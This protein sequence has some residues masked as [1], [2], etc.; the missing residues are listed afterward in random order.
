V[1]AP[2]QEMPKEEEKK[3]VELPQA[4]EPFKITDWD[5]I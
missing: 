4:S 2:K 1:E 5:E 3:S